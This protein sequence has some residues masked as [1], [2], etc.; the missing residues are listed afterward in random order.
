MIP[1]LDLDIQVQDHV[2]FTLVNIMPNSS[3]EKSVKDMQLKK[4]LIY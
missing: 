4:Y 1:A 2:T 3:V